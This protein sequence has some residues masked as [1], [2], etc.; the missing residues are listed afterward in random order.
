[1][2]IIAI[3]NYITNY[4]LNIQHTVLYIG[5]FHGL[6]TDEIRRMYPKEYQKRNR[7]KLAYRYPGVG[8]ES[9][10]DVIERVKPLIIELERQRSSVVVVCHLAALRCIHAY[11]M[12][13]PLKEIPLVHFKKHTIYMLS[14]GP[15]G[16]TCTAIDPK[17]G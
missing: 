16:C 14:P 5:D 2:T 1:M 10:L 17:E 4:T 15:S 11:F 12:G 13:T 6:S 3:T 8:G 9:Y 7:N